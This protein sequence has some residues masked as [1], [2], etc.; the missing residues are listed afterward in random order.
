MK[1]SKTNKIQFTDPT[2]DK[3]WD[4]YVKDHPN[5]SL[6]HTSTW[7]RIIQQSFGY[8]P[9]YMKMLDSQNN[10]TGI[11]PFFLIKSILTGNRLVS[12][13]FSDHCD[14]LLDNPLD[15]NIL[16]P[17]IL[18]SAA[19]LKAEYIELKSRLNENFY[20]GAGFSKSENSKN[21]QLLLQNRS[22]ED[23]QKSFH[24]SFILRNIKK[25]QKS[26]LQIVEGKDSDDLKT[27]YNLLLLTRK[28]HG[29]PPHPFKFFKNMWQLMPKNMI[30]MYLAIEDTTAIASIIVVT[31]K[32]TA[33][34]LYG[35]S[36]SSYMVN[37]PNHLL[38]WTAIENAWKSGSEYF[39]FGRT[40]NSNTGLMLF[41]QRWG[42]EETGLPSFRLSLNGKYTVSRSKCAGE[43]SAINRLVQSLPNPLLKIGSNMV[44]KHMG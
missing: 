1:K 38:L 40:G 11:A 30:K 44:Y 17:F 3:R 25:A 2:V 6:Y 18:E 8:H 19:Q 26:P 9:Y 29:L 27:C 20:N 34:Y 28:K 4:D 7:N 31:Y 37:R 21:H 16:H 32:N 10:V 12:L 36:N 42:T 13:P 35:G 43:Q 41:K 14:V 22:L 15:M 39:D 23:I 33:Y 24:K 5:G